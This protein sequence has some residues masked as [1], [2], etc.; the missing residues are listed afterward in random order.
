M[1]AMSPLTAVVVYE[2]MYGNTKAIATAVAEG[3]SQHGD[4]T[5]YEVSAAPM[6]FS[7]EVDLVVVG[8]PTHAFG[9]SRDRTRRDAARRAERPLVSSSTGLRE[10]LA[11]L[12]RDSIAAAAFDTKISKPRLPGSAARGAERRLRKLGFRIVAP[13]TTFWVSGSEGPLVAGEGDRARRWGEQ[14]A[15][16]LGSREGRS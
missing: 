12:R 13:A 10:W 1:D 11:S 14:L 2:S 15:G 4:V 5:T 7:A 9:L 6:S 16:S 8:G 3:L